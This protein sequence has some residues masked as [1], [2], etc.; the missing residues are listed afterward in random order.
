[1]DGAIKREGWGCN[2]ED[3]GLEVAIVLSLRSARDSSAQIAQMV[4]R[5]TTHV[6]FVL[7]A[8]SEPQRYRAC[9]KNCLA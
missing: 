8:G 2:L 4:R 6:K 9:L 5:Q 3:F 7:I 1:M